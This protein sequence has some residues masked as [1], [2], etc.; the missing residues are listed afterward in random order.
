MASEEKNSCAS[1]KKKIYPRVGKN[2]NN[3]KV[4]IVQ[5]N[6]FN[7]DQAV[8]TTQCLLPEEGCQIF[9]DKLGHVHSSQCEQKNGHITL[10]VYDAKKKIVKEDDFYYPA[11]CVCK[12]EKTSD[13]L[14]SIRG[15]Q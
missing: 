7:L 11:C 12:Y 6:E 9:D 1:I 13:F 2:K 8:T 15:K 10:K 14:K 3:K 4:F 5:A